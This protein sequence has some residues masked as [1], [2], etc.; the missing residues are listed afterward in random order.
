MVLQNFVTAKEV[1]VKQTYTSTSMTDFINQKWFAFLS[2]NIKK[3]KNKYKITFD[4]QSD[5]SLQKYI[6]DDNILQNKEY[7]PSDLTKIDTSNIIDNSG[8]SYLRKSAQLAFSKMASDFNK[9]FDKQFYLMSAYRTYEDQAILFEYGCSLNRC[10]KIW[11]S[12]HQ[13]G[14][15]IDIHLATQKW[16]KKLSGEYLQ[17]M[18]ESAYKYWYINTY[19]KWVEVDGKMSE[20]WHWR[21]VWV[22]L[23]TELKKQ[24]LS[25]AEYYKTTVITRHEA[26]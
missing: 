23:A 19:R 8:R 14:L 17:R 25:F 24:D 3:A 15:A 13:L 26:I 18:N 9:K 10:A 4:L 2:K 20:V 16:Y 7:S 22:P 5:Y 12:E 21:Y 1:F 6:S 11:W